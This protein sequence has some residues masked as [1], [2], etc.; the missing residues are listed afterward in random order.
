[1]P[2]AELFVT[3]KL[4]CTYHSRVQECLDQTLRDLNLT[5]LDLYLVHWPVPLNPKGEPEARSVG[6]RV[7]GGGADA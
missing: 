1:M 4:W 5:Y 7:G 2:R 6:R 3:S